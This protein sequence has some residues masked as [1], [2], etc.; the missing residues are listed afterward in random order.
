MMWPCLIWSSCS[1][2]AASSSSASLLASC[3]SPGA[4]AW[5][6]IWRKKSHSIINHIILLHC[7]SDLLT[8]RRKEARGKLWPENKSFVNYVGC[9]GD[10]SVK[11][12]VAG[13]KQFFFAELWT[14]SRWVSSRRV[15][16]A[17]VVAS[18]ERI[19]EWEFVGLIP[20]IRIFFQF[21]LC[22]KL[23]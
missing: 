5:L 14:R 7:F 6:Q 22:I 23:S 17:E 9:P 4:L 20:T 15:E 21:T 13:G 18:V 1:T 12:E 19:K 8:R 2:T 10:H 11:G 16:Q 3:T